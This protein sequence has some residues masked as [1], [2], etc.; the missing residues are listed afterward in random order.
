M[1]M[2]YRE[3]MNRV[4]ALLVLAASAL[5][6]EVGPIRVSADLTI[7]LFPQLVVVERVPEPS[8]IVVVYQGS[9]AESVFR[10]HD[11]DL[12]ARGWQRVKYEVKKNE[13]KAEYRKGK[14][15]ASLSVK[16]KKGR[17][18]VRVKEG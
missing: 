2:G 11:Q 15:K 10:F 6:L 13:W 5:A 8:G 14:A 3:G 9:Q 4:Y 7:R 17:I 12:R 16:D 18:E 1:R